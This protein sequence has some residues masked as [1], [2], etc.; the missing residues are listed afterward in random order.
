[1]SEGEEGFA[2][3]KP[4]IHFIVQKRVHDIADEHS[5]HRAPQHPHP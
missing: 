4:L 3:V 5:A 1:M 2:K